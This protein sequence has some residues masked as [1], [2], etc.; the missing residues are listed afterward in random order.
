VTEVGVQKITSL[1]RCV[2]RAREAYGAAGPGIRTDYNL[3][4]AAIL[5]VIRACDTAIDLANMAIRRRRLGVPN[6]SRDSFAALVRENIIEP[7]L[8]DRLKKMVGFRNLAVHQYREL[9]LDILDAVIR[10]NL[11][12]LLTFAGAIRAEL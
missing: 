6:E 1:Q 11:D 5:N 4:D 12:D 3:Q 2:A 7:N 9:D 10:I 8:G